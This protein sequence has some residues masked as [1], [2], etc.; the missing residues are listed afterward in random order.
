MLVAFNIQICYDIKYMNNKQL[1]LKIEE[2]LKNEFKMIASYEGKS[3]NTL[4]SQLI[5]QHVDLKKKEIAAKEQAKQNLATQKL[6]YVD[7][8]GKI[9]NPGEVPPSFFGGKAGSF[10]E[11]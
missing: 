9:L 5:E 2:G 6:I 8:D 3:M 10:E 11:F 4:M 7:N 1:I